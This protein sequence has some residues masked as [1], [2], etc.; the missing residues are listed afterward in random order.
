MLN[1]S[2][3]TVTCKAT[4]CDA[5]SLSIHEK[6]PGEGVYHETEFLDVGSNNIFSDIVTFTRNNG[7]SIYCYDAISEINSTPVTILVQGRSIE[8]IINVFLPLQ[9]LLMLLL[10][11]VLELIIALSR[12]VGSQCL[13]IKD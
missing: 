1:G 3:I 10:V 8:I 5:T 12:L 9:I 2:I 13:H 11:F 7:S 4:N 6:K